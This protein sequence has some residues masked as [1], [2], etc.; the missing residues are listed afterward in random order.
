MLARIVCLLGAF[1]VVLGFL[2]AGIGNNGFTVGKVNVKSTQISS[3]SL[4]R[5]QRLQA[6]LAAGDSVVLIG[7]AADSG[8]G[9]ST[10]M[11]R[12]T[13]MF[14]TDG[15]KFLGGGFGNGGWET[16]TLVSESTTVICLDD[17]HLNDRGG[18]KISG[19]TALDGAEQKFDLMYEQLK[20]LKSGKP[21][22]KPIYN[23]VNG[24]LDTPEL[25]EPTPIVI[26]EGLH[27]MYD[28]R[29]ASLL[30]FTIYLDISD[31][32]KFAWKIQRDMAE[33]GHSLEAIKASIE[34]R[35]PDFDQFVAPQRSKADIVIQVLP[36]QLVAE[37]GKVLRVKMIQKEGKE[38][39]SPAYLFDEGSTISWTPCGRK[40][41]CSYPGIKF[42][43]GP[44]TFF[45][46][47]VSVIEMDGEFDNLQELIYVESHLSNTGT[48]FY[49]E[50]TQQLLKMSNSPGSNNGTGFFQTLTALKIREVYEKITKKEV[51]YSK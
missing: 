46:N 27:P 32:I 38:I 13:G 45:D 17:Y 29:V 31:E 21:I 40:L 30:D 1:P 22:K 26:V 6:K 50:L 33:R 36:S 39:F 16:N 2:N 25:V 15:T 34:A 3:K 41:T 51:A 24:T 48:K 8:C 11:R 44:D 5:L 12:L 28:D 23:H 43:Y 42:A 14:G 7:V 35:K 37:T 19:R 49:G 4:G 20:E 9:K 10:F 47:E 18:R